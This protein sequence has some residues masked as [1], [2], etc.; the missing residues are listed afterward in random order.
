MCS[1]GT[2]LSTG[3]VSPS[4]LTLM[5]RSSVKNS[6]AHARKR[7]RDLLMSERCALMST[8]IVTRG[9]HI[10]CHVGCVFERRELGHVTRT[11]RAQYAH[12]HV[13]TVFASVL[14]PSPVCAETITRIPA[15]GVSPC[16]K[17]G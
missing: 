8:P 13:E 15:F 7:P 2:F 1:Y 14:A 11:I 4:T 5:M 16:I 10:E 9:A 12:A 17:T 3:V 6:P